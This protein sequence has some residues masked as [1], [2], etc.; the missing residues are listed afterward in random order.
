M[1]HLPPPPRWTSES[2]K[3][4][5]ETLAIILAGAWG[6]Y[7]FVYQA[8]I[9]PSHLPPYV[10]VT[11]ELQ[12]VGLTASKT[13]CLSARVRIRN[14]G[15]RRVYV[16]AAGFTVTG[17]SLSQLNDSLSVARAEQVL[18]GLAS[19]ES[20][21]SRQATLAVGVIV[22]AGFWF[23]ENEELVREFLVFTRSNKYDVADLTVTVK[24][25]SELPAGILQRWSKVGVAE[26][27]PN[28][29]IVKG[30]DTVKYDSKNPEHRKL[31]DMYH[32]AVVQT[33]VWTTLQP[34]P[35]GVMQGT[36]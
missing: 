1:W 14:P 5:V 33:T 4:S 21:F 17:R 7:T 26:F 30:R 12:V 15:H 27:W 9:A 36:R 25:A 31:S 20:A 3:N 22:N 6:L 11:P 28:T 16:L 24:V 19:S 23:E 13:V 8:K 29:F 35:T 2:I 10:V 34:N 32:V 18:N